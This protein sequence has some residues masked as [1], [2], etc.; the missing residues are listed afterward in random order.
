MSESWATWGVATPMRL[1]LD[2]FRTDGG[3]QM[4]AGRVTKVHEYTEKMRAGEDFEPVVAFFDGEFYWLAD[5]FQ[6]HGAARAAP[7][8]DL[9]ANVL[10][11]SRRD[12]VLYACGANEQHGVKRTDADRRK[13]VM[14]LLQDPEWS[15][16][17]D[18]RIRK[19]A[20]VSKQ[21][22]AAVRHELTGNATPRQ[23]K[24]DD[25]PVVNPTP[26]RSEWEEFR[27]ELDEWA[28][29]LTA[30]PE[31]ELQR[32]GTRIARRRLWLMTTA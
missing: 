31:K 1:S 32:I 27:A 7:R 30:R 24:Q 12:A 5:G 26:P 11:G 25:A 17:D 6:R 19:V 16:W 4:R 3:T 8:E 18:E 22:L 10:Q 20:R 9:A 29:V 15:T 28:E 13:A 23:G 21:R 14:T 2:R